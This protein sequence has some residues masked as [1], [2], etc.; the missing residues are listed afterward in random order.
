MPV[1]IAN[2]P[3]QGIPQKPLR[4]SS[5]ECIL[6][7]V[8]RG[9]AVRLGTKERTIRV[10]FSLGAL[11]GG[12]GALLYVALWLFLPRSGEDRSIAQRLS[13]DRRDKQMVLLA[14]LGVFIVLVSVGSVSF[15][16]G[17]SFTWTLL[18]SVVGIFAVWR[19]SSPDERRHLQ[20]FLNAAPVVGS[21]T[22]RGWKAVVV[23]VVPGIILVVVGLNILNQIG[24][25]WGAAVPALLGALVLVG[26]LLILLTPWWLQNVRDL[27]SERR[28][29]VRMQER[30]AIMGHLHDSVLQTLTLIE[31]CA[32]NE[33]DVVRLARA[34]ERELRLWLFSPELFEAAGAASTSL[35]AMVGAIE[36]EIESD[37]GIR[38][39]L[40]TVGDCAP[41]EDVVALVAAGREAAINAAKWSGAPSISIYAEVGADDISIFVRDTGKGFDVDA[42]P[43]DRRGIAVSI[44]QRIQ[45]HGGGSMI[46]STPGAGAEVELVLRRRE[47]R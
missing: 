32:A 43:S 26:G 30:T 14:L 46:R 36:H 9:C 6:G 27:S 16:F 37:Y 7:G 39:E 35:V 12:V 45:D 25:I 11:A 13:K 8:A 29:R 20:D 1:T 5:T 10:L 33:A 17:W 38:V 31:R 2:T 19:G 23:R 22:A 41:D 42:V 28:Q 44:K 24:G 15:T 47:S 40:V 3:I 34:H 18:P 4:R 21:T